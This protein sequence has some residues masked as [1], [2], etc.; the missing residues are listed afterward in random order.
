LLD[1]LNRR[2]AK[3]I[4]QAEEVIEREKKNKEEEEDMMQRSRQAGQS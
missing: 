4:Q 2:V 1:I 3:H